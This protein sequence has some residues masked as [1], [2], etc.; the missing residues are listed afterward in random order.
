[1]LVFISFVENNFTTRR[2]LRR[3]FSTELNLVMSRC[4][5]IAT[6]LHPLAPYWLAVRCSSR[7]CEA[8]RNTVSV[9]RFLYMNTAVWKVIKV[10]GSVHG[11]GREQQHPTPQMQSKQSCRS[12][13]AWS[14]DSD[15]ADLYD[16]VEYFHL[17]RGPLTIAA[18]LATMYV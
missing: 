17:D 1:M 8:T 4:F 11:R 2:H 5:L 6:Q 15:L 9:N 7:G 18:A 10:L 16:M 13:R 14:T 3:T 12:S